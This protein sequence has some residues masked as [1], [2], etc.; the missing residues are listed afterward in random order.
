MGTKEFQI[1]GV[2]YIFLRYQ[3]EWVFPVFNIYENGLGSPISMSLYSIED[4]VVDCYTDITVNLPECSRSAGCQFID[5]NNNDAGILDWLEENKFGKRTGNE[6]HSGF[7]TYPEF[8]F[9]KGEKFWE[10]RN[11]PEKVINN[12]IY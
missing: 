1:N 8:D 11:L 6:G 9:Y 2:K 7:C 5:M 10:Y 12:L 4:G 3:D